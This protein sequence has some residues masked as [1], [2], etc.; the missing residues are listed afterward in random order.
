MLK[1]NIIQRRDP[2]DQSAAPKF[3]ASL[4]RVQTI[5][6]E[7]I[8]NE[9]AEKSAISKGDV[10]SIVTNLIDLIPKELSMG[11][12]VNLGKL[13]TFWL[14]INSNGFESEEEVNPDVAIKKVNIRFRPSTV[15]KKL[16]GGLKFDRL[17]FV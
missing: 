9:L 8:A 13:G 17:E 10:M 4:K 14:N 3:Y 2:R 6:M 16:I 7:Y 15:L 5:D 11:R 1:Y 12:T